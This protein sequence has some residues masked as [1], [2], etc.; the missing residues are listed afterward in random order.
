MGSAQMTSLLKAL[1]DGD[2]K[3]IRNYLET[4]SD[5]IMLSF[6]AAIGMEASTSTLQSITRFIVEYHKTHPWSI[7]I[8]TSQ[9][10]VLKYSNYDELISLYSEIWSQFKPG[11][12]LDALTDTL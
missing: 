7:E 1:D 2:T 8:I 3:A 10:D 12:N 4:N 6:Y 5:V 9:I 11:S